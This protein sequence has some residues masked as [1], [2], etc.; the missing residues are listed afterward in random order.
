MIYVRR[1]LLAWSI[2]LHSLFLDTFLNATYFF[3]SFL[4]VWSF[5]MISSGA[6]EWLEYVCMYVIRLSE[7]WG[8]KK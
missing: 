1:S 3:A 7:G 4:S 2:F 5:V 8:Q 6:T